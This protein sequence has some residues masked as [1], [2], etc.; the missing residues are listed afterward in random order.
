MKTFKLL[1]TLNESIPINGLADKCTTETVVKSSIPGRV[2]LNFT[3]H[4]QL[5][6]YPA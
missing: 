5:V 4:S 6:S 3:W 2:K 1:E